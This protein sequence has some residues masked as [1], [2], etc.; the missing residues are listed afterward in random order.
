[1]KLMSLKREGD[2]ACHPCLSESHV[3]DGRTSVPP[4]ET[5]GCQHI[6]EMI[7]FFIGT[8]SL[9]TFK[10]VVGFLIFRNISSGMQVHRIKKSAHT[11]S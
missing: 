10:I 2:S 1:M 3:R 4:A 8:A 7:L 11:Y 5:S 6:R 9:F